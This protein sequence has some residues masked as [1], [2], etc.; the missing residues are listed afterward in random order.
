[1][2]TLIQT[3]I[4]TAIIGSFSLS[5][6]SQTQ[7]LI[8]EQWSGAGGTSALFHKNITGNDNTRNIYVAGSTING[9]NNSDVMIQKF[10]PSGVYFGNKLMQALGA[11][12]TLRL[13]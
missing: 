10:H 7:H 12:M 3:L 2:K 13:I 1:M 5:G 9:I 11:V 8:S 4:I 6:F